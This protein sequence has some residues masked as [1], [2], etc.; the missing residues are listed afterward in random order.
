MFI[1]LLPTDYPLPN[2]KNVAVSMIDSGKQ[3]FV[4]SFDDGT[5]NVTELTKQRQRSRAY[6]PEEHCADGHAEIICVSGPFIS[7]TVQE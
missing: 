4:K 7:I 1:V 2:P 5:S 3:L 6:W